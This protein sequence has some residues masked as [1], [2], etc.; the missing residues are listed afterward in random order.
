MDPIKAKISAAQLGALTANGMVELEA[1]TRRA[2]RVRLESRDNEVWNK[3]YT[4]EDGNE[5]DVL[6]FPDD[7]FDDVLE[8]VGA[9]GEKVKIGDMIW[10]PESDVE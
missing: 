4:D 1:D 6:V 8:A 10:L 7:M 9:E 5:Y 3:V 2:V